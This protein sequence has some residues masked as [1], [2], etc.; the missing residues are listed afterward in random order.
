MKKKY[1]IIIVFLFS[2]FILLTIIYMDHS[3]HHLLNSTNLPQ[4]VELNTVKIISLPNTVTTTGSVYAYQS[5]NISAQVSGYVTQIY[6]QEGEYVTAGTPLIQLDNRSEKD[7][8]IS[9]KAALSLSN[10]QYKRDQKLLSRGLITQDIYY[11]VKVTNQQN[12]ATANADQTQLDNKTI[13]APFNGTIGKRSIS[14]GDYVTA[15]NPITTL[16]DNHQLRVEYTLPSSYQY[17]IKLGQKVIVTTDTSS[18]NSYFIMTG[19]VSYIASSIDQDT[20]T[21]V[22][23]AILDNKNHLLKSG[24]FVTITQVLGPAKNAIV[25]PTQSIFASLSGYYVF[26]V[27]DN[28]A[29]KIPIKIG[30]KF[31]N[32]IE[33][34]QGLKPNDKIVVAGQNHLSNDQAVNVVP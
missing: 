11:N 18:S 6:Y 12:Q 25:V 29:I 17:Q 24:Q 15:G 13:K 32:V 21:I 34:I 4:P 10:L 31:K 23:H 7:A 33:V 26:S 22:V 9:A 27:K 14:V 20:Q 28:K 3:H 19:K 8:L 1:I 30:K 16:V 2:V 5:T